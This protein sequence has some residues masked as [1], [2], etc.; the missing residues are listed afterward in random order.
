MEAVLQR[1]EAVFVPIQEDCSR[2]QVVAGHQV[3]IGA[4]KC[5]L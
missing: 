1:Q 4:I 3:R 5:G 2:I